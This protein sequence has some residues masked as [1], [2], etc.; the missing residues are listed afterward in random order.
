[1]GKTDRQKILKELGFS[2]AENGNWIRKTDKGEEILVPQ[3][4]GTYIPYIRPN[5]FTTEESDDLRLPAIGIPGII[6]TQQND[7]NS[8]F[9]NMWEQRKLF[10]LF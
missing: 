2:I 5:E 8:V 1:M 4:N 7:I 6:I 9:S 3:D 10:W